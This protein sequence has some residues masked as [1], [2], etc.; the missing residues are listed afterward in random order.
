MVLGLV[1]L[2]LESISA[3][4]EHRLAGRAGF[5]T[6]GSGFGGEGV[7]CMALRLWFF[8][9][10]TEFCQPVRCLREGGCIGLVA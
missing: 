4:G 10:G 6:R 3:K 8:L 9:G 1:A 2:G 5:R 7:G